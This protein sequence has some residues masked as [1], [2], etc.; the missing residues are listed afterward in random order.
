[1]NLLDLENR[2]GKAPG[3]YQCSLDESGLPFIFMNSVGVNQDVFTLLHECGHSF[4]QFAAKKYNLAYNREAPMEFSEV[5]S[6]SMER[7][8]MRYLNEFYTENEK[9]S[10][11][12]MEDQDVFRLL[13][14]VA[15]VDKFQHWLYTNPN[16][17]SKD[18]NRRW[19][20]I[21]DEFN[22]GVDWHGLEY[23]QEISWM[24]QLHIFEHPFYYIEYG[25]AQFGALQ[26]WDHYLKGK[27]RAVERYKAALGYGGTR[28]LKEL[29]SRDA[30]VDYSG[31]K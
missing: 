30:L 22:Y 17:S 16:H 14:W 9:A 23:L 25:I 7:F 2:I 8:G 26:L 1:M 13:I 18:R 19:M 3:G 15:I 21:N 12:L 27:T 24:K 11:I 29:F 6:M 5:A 4:H 31:L 28:S 10:A 20:E